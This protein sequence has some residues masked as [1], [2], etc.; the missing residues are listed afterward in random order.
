[1]KIITWGLIFIFIFGAGVFLSDIRDV[2]PASFPGA[3]LFNYD[4]G[5][6]DFSIEREGSKIQF[7]PIDEEYSLCGIILK[8]NNPLMQENLKRFCAT[9]QEA[10]VKLGKICKNVQF[11]RQSAFFWKI[12][13][14]DC[15]STNLLNYLDYQ[16]IC[17]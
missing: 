17:A 6:T 10:C 13:K 12:S 9:G 1:M 5:G 15:S 4:E 2:M 16:A 11:K 7:S 3:K 8:D 14:F